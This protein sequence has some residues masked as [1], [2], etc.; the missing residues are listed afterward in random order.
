MRV[1]LQNE[2]LL[3][4]FL[5][6]QNL[7]HYTRINYILLIVIMQSFNSCPQCKRIGQFSVTRLDSTV[8]SKLLNSPFLSTTCI[9]EEY[10]LLGCD[11]M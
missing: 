2:I 10:H 3:N 4:I 11:A 9:N 6:P 8:G 1:T 7:C 5:S